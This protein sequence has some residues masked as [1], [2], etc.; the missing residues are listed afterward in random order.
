MF[1][2]RLPSVVPTIFPSL[3]W[4]RKVDSSDNQ[5]FFT[6]DDGPCPEITNFVLEELDKYQA[7]ATFFSIGKNL[8]A[9]ADLG[10]LIQSSGHS[11]GNH[12][13]NHVNAWQVSYQ[14]YKEDKVAC[15]VVFDEL[16]IS[17]VGFRPPYGRVNRELIRDLASQE[18][19]FMWSVL[20]GDYHSG[21]S[22]KSIINQ[23]IK[24][25]KPGSIIVFHDSQKAFPHLKIVLP[26][27]LSYCHGQGF[28]LLPL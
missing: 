26:A 20:T 24:A 7:K 25:I 21:L 10:H 2:H 12:T 14:A 13:M 6:F 28:Q 18:S 9:H 15:D 23:C 11:L 3:I 8:L 5:V 27:L 16:G 4:S 19:V 17:S 22:S 1:I